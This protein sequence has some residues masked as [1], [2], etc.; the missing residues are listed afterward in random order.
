MKKSSTGLTMKL[1][2]LRSSLGRDDSSGREEERGR[3][4]YEFGIVMLYSYD[5]RVQ[6]SV[7]VGFGGTD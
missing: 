1:S 6:G 4:W 3:Q 2:K 5:P 7:T